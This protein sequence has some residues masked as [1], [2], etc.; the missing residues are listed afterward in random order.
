MRL[1]LD[2]HALIWLISDADRLSP[3]AA[4]AI[5]DGDAVYASHVSMWEMAI[6]SRA[7]K[8]TI[9]GSLGTGVGNWFATNVQ[10]AKLLE[11]PI[12]GAHVAAV[13]FLPDHHRDPFDRLLVA[14]ATIERLTLVTC[15]ALIGPYGIATVW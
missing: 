10:R 14:Q 12:S 5:R 11:L 7:G 13:E 4:A 2:T 3:P 1:L 15:D 6:K 9:E 8:L